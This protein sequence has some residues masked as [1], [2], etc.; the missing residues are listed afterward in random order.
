M[1]NTKITLKHMHNGIWYTE[2]EKLM[3]LR[4]LI[5]NRLVYLT[6]IWV[7]VTMIY[8]RCE[9]NFRGLTINKI[10]L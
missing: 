3:C 7:Y 6:S 4:K 10:K 5:E 9:S 1:I 8:S 2:Y